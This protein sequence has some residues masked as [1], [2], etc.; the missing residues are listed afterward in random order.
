MFSRRDL[1]SSGV[2]GALRPRS[3]E[4][5]SR[6]IDRLREQMAQFLRSNFKFPDV[7]DV[8][9]D[10]FYNVY[11]WHVKNGQEPSV[12]RLPDGRYAIPFMF[13]RMILRPETEATFVG[14]PYDNR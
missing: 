6:L 5:P 7:C 11:D 9:C 3:S 8:G 13:T 4:L 12:G 2:I 1:L 10:V 14:Y